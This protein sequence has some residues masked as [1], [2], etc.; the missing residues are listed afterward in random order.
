MK[1]L[2]IESGADCIACDD[3]V[4]L[5]ESRS[6]DSKSLCSVMAVYEMC[7]RVVTGESEGFRL[8]GSYRCVIS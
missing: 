7:D 6:R 1:R 4:I 5:C 2:V 8:Y 3:C